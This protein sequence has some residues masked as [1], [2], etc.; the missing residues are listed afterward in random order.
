VDFY[1][2]Q[3]PRPAVQPDTRFCRSTANTGRTGA[4]ETHP[5]G[6]CA[7]MRWRMQSGS[8]RFRGFRGLGYRSPLV[9]DDNDN[10]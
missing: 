8:R 5:F 7:H 1:R 6:Q 2:L 9:L 10:G 3:R 4:S